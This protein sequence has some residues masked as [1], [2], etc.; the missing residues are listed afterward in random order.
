[1]K[2][3]NL[4]K[5]NKSLKEAQSWWDKNVDKLFGVLKKGARALPGSEKWLVPSKMQELVA[6][7]T[8][9]FNAYRSDVYKAAEIIQKQLN[10][11]SKEDSALLVKAL[12][13][14]LET[15]LFER[16]DLLSPELN[17]VYKRLRAIIDKNA[18]EL[19]EAGLL[20]PNDKIDDYLKRFYKQ[21]LDDKNIFQKMT[22]SKVH[23]RKDLSYDERIALGMIEDA[24]FVIP[25]T[26][27]AQRMQLARGEFLKGIKEMYAKT[28]PEDEYVY[29]SD[30]SYEGSKIKKYGALSGT[31]IP[32]EV[33]QTLDDVHILKQELGVLERNLYAVVDHIKV[34]VTVKNLG[35]HLYNIASNIQIACLQ[36]NILNVGRMI[37][38]AKTD[39][40]AFNKL[41][42]E[43]K[44]F[45]LDSM[46]DDMENL[47]IIHKKENKGVVD[48]AKTILKNIYM[49]ADSKMGRGVRKAYDWEDKIF[50][51]SAYDHLKRK[52]EKK[53]GRK[54]SEGERMSVFKEATAPYANYS[55]PLPGAWRLADKSGVF[56]FVHYM[57]KS[58]P[59]VVKLIAKNP[60]KYMAMQIAIFG[61]SASM[62][63]D[64]DDELKPT[65]AGNNGRINLFGAKEWSPLG[66]NGWYWNAGRMMPGM[67]FGSFTVDGGF[68]GSTFKITSGTTPLGYKIGKKYDT[69]PK[70][71]FDRALALVENYAPPFT[72]G[73]YA[74]RGTKKALGVG[75]KNYYDEEMSWSEFIGRMFGI[76]HFNQQK[77]VASH[78]KQ[79]KNRL[80][81]FIKKEPHNK[82]KYEKEFNE[83]VAMIK[84][85]A[86]RRGVKP[87]PPKKKKSQKS[88]VKIDIEVPKQLIQF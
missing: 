26:I 49:S 76:R 56:P 10:T 80:R 50:K 45:G 85:Q 69:T 51:L 58:T 35:T 37:K 46:L 54:L 73:R 18:K 24:S 71:M 78:L 32:K 29:V 59:A 61:V 65:W 82:A 64:E 13:G 1:M 14:S 87:P 3:D 86:K 19:I 67:K 12:D 22:Q 23:K 41:L 66:S 7:M 62:F 16:P 47:N 40:E 28:K 55:T 81:Y 34:N 5:S 36:G 48:V 53:L 72:V 44:P 27:A 63:A 39:K 38:L 70:A 31:Y 43:V 88:F 74:L 17:E 30:E 84:A 20:D 6:D 68:V 21:H 15:G 25:R 77:E 42:Q 11:L 9:R 60:L 2:C 52:Y 83:T 57:Y 79:A 75:Q 8:T 33:K 4:Q